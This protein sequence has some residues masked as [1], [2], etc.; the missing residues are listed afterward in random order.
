MCQVPRRVERDQSADK[1]S[2][3]SKQKHSKKHGKCFQGS[4]QPAAQEHY[5]K[6]G[7]LVEIGSEEDREVSVY[8]SCDMSSP[9]GNAIQDLLFQLQKLCHAGGHEMF[10]QGQG[11]QSAATRK[12]GHEEARACPSSRRQDMSVQRLRS[13]VTEG[14]EEWS[15]DEFTF[16]KSE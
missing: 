8:A 10:L 16:Q 2:K 3:S 5:P 7:H 11:T 4:Q 6:K 15:G 13:Q 12:L 1:E 14:Q 9:V